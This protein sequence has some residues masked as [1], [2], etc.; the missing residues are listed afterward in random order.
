MKKFYELLDVSES[1]SQEEIKKSYR[2]L[3]LKYHPD[4]NNNN[5]EAIDKFQQINEAY[6]TLGNPEKRNEYDSINKNP[7]SNCNI[8]HNFGDNIEDLF[9]NLIFGG[10]GMPF[11]GASG[12]QDIHGNSPLYFS[13]L[14]VWIQRMRPGFVAPSLHRRKQSL[15]QW[16]NT[17][18][19]LN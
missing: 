14:F 4:K 12:M 17:T 10:L 1:S 15:T 9:N 6:E 19:C 5:P 13:C 16:I 7:F 2:K 3:S 11:M 18:D 8:N